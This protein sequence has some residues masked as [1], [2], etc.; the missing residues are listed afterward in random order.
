MTPLPSTEA[1]LLVRTD[2]TD[3]AA[4]EAT[5]AAS[6]AENEHGSRA[7]L[8]VVDDEAFTG[9]TWQWLRSAILDLDRRGV[10]LYVADTAAL[11]GDHPIQVVDLSR[12]ARQPFR[13]LAREL[14]G[15]DG[16]VTDATM[17]WEDFADNVESDGT[18][19]G[20]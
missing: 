5:R 11:A 20:F 16:T 13:C 8:H 12:T 19:R 10:L 3:D 2:F 18:Y 4:W 17:E 9:A 1:S 7:H 15:I 6:L 14:A